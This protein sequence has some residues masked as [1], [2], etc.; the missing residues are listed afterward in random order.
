[1]LIQC[2][3]NKDIDYEISVI[4]KSISILFSYIQASSFFVYIK[5]FK[6]TYYTTLTYIML[7]QNL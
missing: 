7:Q 5:C 4:I 6:M 1:M 3:L 2:Q